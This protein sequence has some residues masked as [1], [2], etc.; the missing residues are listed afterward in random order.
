MKLIQVKINA[1]FFNEPHPRL[2]AV[3]WL[4]AAFSLAVIGQIEFAHDRL[5]AGLVAYA[6]AA[7]VFCLVIRSNRPAEAV[8]TF[9]AQ[10]SFTHP[11]LLIWLAIAIALLIA[12][13]AQYPQPNPNEHWETLF[14]WLL[15][16]GLFVG[17]VLRS[18]SWRLPGW[19]MIKP[20]LIAHRL[21]IAGV[22]VL[23]MAALVFRTADLA[24]H[25]YAFAN[26]EGWMGLEGRDILR[27]AF[28]KFFSVGWGTQPILTFAPTALSLAV[29]GD[30]IF[31]VRLVS[32]IEGT[33][34]VLFLYLAGREMFNRRLAFLAAVVL[35]A[36]PVHIHFSRVG[37]N[38]IITGM[39]AALLVWLVFRALRRGNPSDYLWAGLAT[40]SG[41]YTYLGTR[42]TIALAAGI[43][44]YMCISQRRFLR[45]H[46]LHLLV[47]AGAALIVSGPQI[48]YFLANPDTFMARMT[49]EGIL[50]NGWLQEQAA[51]GS[52]GVFMALLGQ[53]SSSSLVYTSLPAPYGFYASPIPY[54]PA[55][56]AI[57]MV[58]G[59]GYAFYQIRKPAAMTLLAWFWS[60]TILGG[61]L[62]ASPPASQ[63]LI[64]GFPAAALM[65][66]VCLDQ[67]AAFLE[68]LAFKLPRLNTRL[69]LTGLCTLAV[70][71]IGIDGLNFYFDEY[72]LEDYYG[73]ASNELIYEST[74]LALQLDPTYEFEMLT[75]P[76]VFASFANFQFFIPNYQINEI[77][78]PLNPPS[79]ITNTSR[80][81]Y[82]AIPER[83][84]ELQ[85]IQSTLPGGNWV[86]INRQFKPDQ[87]LMLAYIY[88]SVDV[89]LPEAEKAGTPWLQI[90]MI[91]HPLPYA[92]LLIS[93]AVA[94][95]I[96]LAPL[97]WKRWIKR[98]NFEKDRHKTSF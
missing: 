4:A 76:R 30:S 54:F 41:I 58:I 93:I 45:S 64:M 96:W 56:A 35:A 48:A 47:F 83:R 98:S 9:R 80:A 95:D 73:D 13:M 84:N 42:L 6:A 24:L 51:Q 50:Q 78:D 31:A 39:Y 52:Q 66:A 71:G 85:A 12:I 90:D 74:R 29:L 27:N 92:L 7:V 14:G 65:V 72:R 86:E 46:L 32:A 87:K 38:N 17:G 77:I 34:T 63:R 61:M 62:T 26:D 19:S 3:L 44:G 18:T 15:S 10:A 22:A 49:S 81:I 36:M 91:A 94:L 33:L 69:V 68:R 53:L 25:P 1:S 16:I 59:M 97:I 79:A 60:V 55:L 11:S 5:P 37:F 67:T 21:E 57:L 8:P 82:V 28:T 70:I 2:Y 23:T 89:K 40:G 20:F 43:L 75:A 88:P